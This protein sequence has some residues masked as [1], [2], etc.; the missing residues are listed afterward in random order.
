MFTTNYSFTLKFEQD[1]TL[2]QQKKS[3]NPITKESSR[4]GPFANYVAKWCCGDGMLF[5]AVAM[6]Q[7]DIS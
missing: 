3:C 5:R 2:N 1:T 7:P 6:A 4:T